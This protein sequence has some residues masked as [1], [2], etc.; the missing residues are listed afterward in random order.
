M[1]VEALQQA[2]P[3]P[4]RRISM[5]D[6]V[7]FVTPRVTDEQ[8]PTVLLPPVEEHPADRWSEEGFMEHPRAIALQ[9]QLS[10]LRRTVNAMQK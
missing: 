10:I 1:Q 3:A 6:A 2:I 9:S 5:A 7:T 4:M 8:G